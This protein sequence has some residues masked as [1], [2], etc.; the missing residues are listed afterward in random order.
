MC[1]ETVGWVRESA[2]AARE[3]EPSSATFA[4]TSSCLRSTAP[5][6]GG[7]TQTISGSRTLRRSSPPKPA[8]RRRH[9]RSGC[10]T[11]RPRPRAAGSRGGSHNPGT[12]PP[13]GR[14]SASRNGA[15]RRDTRIRR[16]AWFP[17]CLGR[18]RLL[19]AALDVALDELL[20]VLL[21]DLVDLVQEV[22]EVFL[23]L[24][25]L[26]GQLGTSRPGFLAVCR[27]RRPRFLLLLLSHGHSPPGPCPLT[28]PAPGP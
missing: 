13:T 19:A 7:R 25:A 10:P 2:R 3:N 11:A 16:S 26:L 4:N 15:R 1:S 20:G 8:P 21:E 27:L 18:P 5:G 17:L 28:G 22:V 9:S 12:R 24:L 6:C 14:G 23:Q